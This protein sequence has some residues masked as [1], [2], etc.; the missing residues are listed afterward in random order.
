M[1]TKEKIEAEALC[2]IYSLQPK[3]DSLLVCILVV[4]HLAASTVSLK[5]KSRR[6]CL[7]I[8]QTQI[9]NL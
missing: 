5:R 1:S 6:S 4:A 8:R 7:E 2:I 3:I 9:Q